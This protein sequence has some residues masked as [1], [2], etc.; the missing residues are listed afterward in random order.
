[1]RTGRSGEWYVWDDPAKPT[2]G[3]TDPSL[4][5]FSGVAIWQVESIQLLHLSQ[6][7]LSRDLERSC[8]SSVGSILSPTRVWKEHFLYLWQFTY[9]IVKVMTSLLREWQDSKGGEAASY[10]LVALCFACLPLLQRI[11]DQGSRIKDQESR[12]KDQGRMVEEKQDG[13]DWCL[14]EQGQP[15]WGLKT[16]CKYLRLNLQVQM[17]WAKHSDCP[18]LCSWLHR[19]WISCQPHC[20]ADGQEQGQEEKT[21]LGSKWGKYRKQ[22]DL[23]YFT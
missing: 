20:D 12:I 7:S 8:Y 4:T 22:G 18:L 6:S 3:G 21:I 11:K 14:G 15:G 13:L 16:I 5:H 1:M 2:L 17:S 23:C 9:S 10:L 19:F